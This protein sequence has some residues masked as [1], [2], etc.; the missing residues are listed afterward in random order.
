MQQTRVIAR[1]ALNSS[2]LGSALCTMTIEEGARIAYAS[3]LLVQQLQLANAGARRQLPVPLQTDNNN[4]NNNKEKS[5]EPWP[6]NNIGFVKQPESRDTGKWSS[7]RG[8]Q[9]RTEH[10]PTWCAS[11]FEEA[12]T[13]CTKLPLRPFFSTLTGM[14]NCLTPPLL[15]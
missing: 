2:G 6:V 7:V 14:L 11:S 12:P 5:I 10:N 4:N 3:V 15:K 1:S 8:V 13:L 9:N